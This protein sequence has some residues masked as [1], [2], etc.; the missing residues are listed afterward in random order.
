MARQ[1]IQWPFKGRVDNNARGDQPELTTSDAK[2]VRNYAAGT[3]RM[4]GGQRPGLAKLE[5]SATGTDA[6]QVH[7]T[8]PVRSVSSLV[9]D[10]PAFAYSQTSGDIVADWEN[11]NDTDSGSLDVVVDESGN[12]YWLTSDGTVEKRNAQGVLV[13]S[14]PFPIISEDLLG[15]IA[16]DAEGGVYGVFSG[17]SNVGRLARIVPNDDDDGADL[18]YVVDIE[19]GTYRDLLLR[20]GTLFLARNED[21]EK[22]AYIDAYQGLTSDTPYK[23]A[24]YNATYPIRQI[25]FSKGGIVYASAPADDRVD[26]ELVQNVGPTVIDWTPFDLASYEER[27]HCW[28]DARA[29]QAAAP[30]THVEAFDRRNEYLAISSQTDDFTD[31]TVRGYTSKVWANTNFP[32]WDPN[33]L[34]PYPAYRFD[35]TAG[36]PDEGPR[37]RFNYA[38]GYGL[39]SPLEGDGEWHRDKIST[40]DVLSR[41]TGLYPQVL[42]QTWATTMLVRCKTDVPMVLWIWNGKPKSG[43]KKLP[44]NYV[45]LTINGHGTG[46]GVS[47]WGR[48]FMHDPDEAQRL[49]EYYGPVRKPQALPG[50]VA[51]YS[52]ELSLLQEDDGNGGTTNTLNDLEADDLVLTDGAAWA[53]PEI[54]GAVHNGANSVERLYLITVICEKD[55][56]GAGRPAIRLRVN[57]EAD[58]TG[59]GSDKVSFFPENFNRDKRR[60]VIGSTIFHSPYLSG[61]IQN[62]WTGRNFIGGGFSNFDGWLCEAIT[63]FG[64]SSALGSPHDDAYGVRST[65]PAPPST[66]FDDVERVEAYIAHKWGVAATV[67][68]TG[69]G[70]NFDGNQFRSTPPSGSGDELQAALTGQ[71]ISESLKSTLGITAKIQLTDGSH[72]WAVSG[73]GMG[74]GVVSDDNDG[75]IYTIGPKDPGSPAVTSQDYEWVAQGRKLVDVGPYVRIRRRGFAELSFFANPADGD[76]LTV[77]DGTTTTVLTFRTSPSTTNDV[78]IGT[79]L[80][81]TLADQS[82]PYGF[83]TVFYSAVNGLTPPNYPIYAPKGSSDTRT[84]RVYMIGSSALDITPTMTLT[85]SAP[86]N[87]DVQF[88]QFTGST[89]AKSGSERLSA[90]NCAGYLLVPY[91]IPDPDDTVFRMSVDADGTLYVPRTGPIASGSSSKASHIQKWVPEPQGGS[92]ANSV[93]NSTLTSKNWYYDINGSASADFATS[94]VGVRPEL[95][96][97]YPD[98]SITGPEYIWVANKN[99]DTNE[100]AIPD[101]LTQHKLALIAR[102]ASNQN[103]RNVIRFAVAGTQAYR[104]NGTSWTGIGTVARS[105]ESAFT[106]AVAAYG[107]MFFVDNGLY[108]TYD[109]VKN[110]G[111]FEPWEADTAGEI[112]EGCRL[113]AFY[114]GRMVLG[115]SDKDPHTIFASAVGDPYN[116]DFFPKTESLTKA[117]GGANQDTAR[118]PDVVNAL[119]PFYDDVLLVGGDHSITQYRGD[120]SEIGQ[121]DYFTDVTGMAFGNS[122]ALSPEGL[123]YFFGSRGGVWVMSPRSDGRTQPPVELTRDTIAEELRDIDLSQYLPKLVWDQECQGL[124]VFITPLTGSVSATTQHW[125]WEAR[126]KSWWPQEFNATTLQPYSTVLLEGLKPSDRRVAIGCEDGYVRVFDKTASNDDGTAIESDVLIGPIFAPDT[127]AEQRISSL[128]AIVAN[129]GAGCRYTLYASDNPETLGTAVA[130]GSL[131]A[132]YND[133]VPARARGGYIWIKLENATG[134]G[135]WALESLHADLHLAGRRRDR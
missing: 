56:I 84:I 71:T 113:A 53:A 80:D 106:Q 45:A 123:M 122:W 13:W 34:G 46:H 96:Y 135:Q 93:I 16:V 38:E 10:R 48:F 35:A 32:K 62:V 42:N 68:K 33:G 90:W 52:P 79:D 132:G 8:S 61:Q 6:A 101:L 29:H 115:R 85:S 126:T 74:Y 36:S 70:A 99:L 118:N 108:A 104:L 131:V 94:A 109:P 21:D 73:A 128:H 28:I 18:Q 1:R 2:N 58:V 55:G 60:D 89:G 117:F 119:A 41:S 82:S 77:T 9:Y 49:G 3:E 120:L 116:W 124:H 78:Q 91:V 11:A 25:A 114:R 67:L 75:L 17:G 110:G 19:P 5:D 111:T 64:D 133:R 51:L 103:V 30:G 40:N 57:A 129:I 65:L 92:I 76:T 69:T 102:T 27:I 83:Q 81:T 37:F 97:V 47:E 105:S 98:S 125:F 134:G 31:D 39:T 14:E 24:E 66:F 112:P 63:Y 87:F 127:P 22:E 50:A 121:V 86:S 20:G 54:H 23:S 130:S 12:S 4:Q 100:D 72:T 15:K 7:P 88:Q 59:I 107:Q 26:R 95:E 43:D 44:G